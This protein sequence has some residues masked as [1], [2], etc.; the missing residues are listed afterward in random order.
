[1]CGLT[2]ESR[3]ILAPLVRLER[4]SAESGDPLS[5]TTCFTFGQSVKPMEKGFERAQECQKSI[6]AANDEQMQNGSD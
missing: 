1:M 4:N 5:K 3:H 2:S 6:E